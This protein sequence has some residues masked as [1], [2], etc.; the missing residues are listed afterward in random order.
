MNGLT[1]NVDKLVDPIYCLIRRI[2]QLVDRAVPY[3]DYRRVEVKLQHI[4]IKEP[5][6]ELP[7]RLGVLGLEGDEARQWV[8]GVYVIDETY[9]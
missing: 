9:V 3:R 6:E 1:F 2:G 4:V 8:T 5:L 7:Q